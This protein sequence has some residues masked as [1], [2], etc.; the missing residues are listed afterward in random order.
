MSVF[1]LQ[2]LETKWETEINKGNCF[3]KSSAFSEAYMHYMEAM[4]ISEL[5][6]ENIATVPKHNLR[7]PGMYFTSCI[8]IAYNYWRMQ[9]LTN[10]ADY[11]LY[12]TYKMKQLSDEPAIDPILKQAASVYWLKSVQLYTEFSGK[13]GMPIPDCLDH[14]ET[15]LQLQN[16]KKLFALG[17]DNMN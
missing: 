8:N 6:L 3:F 13:T 14:E 15:Y 5:L 9:D 17:K 16:L 4:I 11:F 1:Q 12:C 10:A 2:Q 7:L